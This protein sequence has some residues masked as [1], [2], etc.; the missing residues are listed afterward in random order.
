MDHDRETLEAIEQAL[1]HGYSDDELLRRLLAARPVADPDFQDQLEAQLLLKQRIKPTMY[2]NGHV[3]P[4]PV[5]TQNTRPI[6][7]VAVIVML[8]VSAGILAAIA[9][10]SGGDS[11]NSAA[12][13]I[14]EQA[15]TVPP[16]VTST[17]PQATPTLVPTSTPIQFQ[18]GSQNLPP[19]QYL[20]VVTTIVEIPVGEMITED[21]LTIV[22]W[23]R[24]D[25]PPAV[26]AE[27]D[28]VL[29]LYAEDDIAAW[30]PIIGTELTTEAP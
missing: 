17:L 10:G 29:G 4:L 15:A 5:T 1:A 14:Q 16:I 11:S 9:L 27:I 2:A 26:F 21:M 19:N 24:E 8:V 7:L 18:S 3:K 20:P 13:A 30:H 25:A 12:P 23:P 28:V 22:Y 6:T